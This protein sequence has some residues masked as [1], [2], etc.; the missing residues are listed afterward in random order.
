MAISV[1]MAIAL[2]GI[3]ILSIW[4]RQT[5]D[6]RLARSDRQS[7]ITLGLRLTGAVLVFLIGGGLFAFTAVATV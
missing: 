6:R 3:G 4:G 1:G 5:L 2:S 7:K